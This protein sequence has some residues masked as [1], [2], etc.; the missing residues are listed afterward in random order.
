MEDWQGLW[1]SLEGQS[2]LESLEAEAAGPYGPPPSRH[3]CRLRN[4]RDMLD[5]NK[6]LEELAENPECIGIPGVPGSSTS[7]S[8]EPPPPPP[9]PPRNARD[10]QDANKKYK[11]LE[12]LAENPDPVPGS[13]T[14]SIAHPQACHRGRRGGRRRGRAERTLAKELSWSCPPPPTTEAENPDVVPGIQPPNARDNQ[15]AK[16]YM[17]CMCMGWYCIGIKKAGECRSSSFDPPPPPPTPPSSPFRLPTPPP[18]PTP[19]STDAAAV[20]SV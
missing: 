5:A 2:L 16:K 14:S 8:S 3:E 1:E 19:P 6:I 17:G 11:I 4:A 15:D 9:Q 20:V 18:W 13:S 10:I 12:E 7:S